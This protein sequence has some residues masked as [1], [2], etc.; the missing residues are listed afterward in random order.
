VSKLV[1]RGVQG[2][3]NAKEG[4]DVGHPLTTRLGGC[5]CHLPRG[6]RCLPLVSVEKPESPPKRRLSFVSVLTA[7]SSFSHSPSEES[8]SVPR[9]HTGFISE[10]TTTLY[11]IR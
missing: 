10:T 1:G 8:S 7:L 4:E 3:G 11:N 2:T 6:H 5:V 9:V